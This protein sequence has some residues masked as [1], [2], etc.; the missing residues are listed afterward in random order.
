V[1]VPHGDLDATRAAKAMFEKQPRWIG[2]L[3]GLRNRIVA[4]LG[5]KTSGRDAKAHLETIG[6]FPVRSA[7]PGRVILGFDDK[8][9]DFRVVVEAVR[10]DG[11]NTVTAATLVRLNYL[12]GRLYLTTIMSFHR[13]ILRAMLARV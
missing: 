5:L 12:F 4:P 9:L 1:T 10:T 2:I 3:V 8:H 13:V 11:G 6:I 7:T